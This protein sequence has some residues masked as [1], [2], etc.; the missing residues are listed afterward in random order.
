MLQVILHAAPVYLP[1]RLG[2]QHPGA[3]AAWGQV[4]VTK[5]VH[6]KQLQRRLQ[7]TKALNTSANQPTKPKYQMHSAAAV[8]LAAPQ[9]APGQ[10]N[11]ATPHASAPRAAIDRLHRTWTPAPALSSTNQLS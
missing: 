5:L 7:L 8:R 9:A 2:S 11:H 3:G 6:N 1:A 4:G 10:Q